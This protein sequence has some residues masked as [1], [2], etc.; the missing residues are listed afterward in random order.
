[1]AYWIQYNKEELN[2]A[3]TRSGLNARVSGIH[4]PGGS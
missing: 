4:A 1:M 3:L 2:A